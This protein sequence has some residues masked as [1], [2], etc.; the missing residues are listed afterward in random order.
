MTTY[1]IKD[2][3]QVFNLIKN[4]AIFYIFEIDIKYK[5]EK[6]I[7]I[8]R[9]K[10][11]NIGELIKFNDFINKDIN[12]IKFKIYNLNNPLNI[13]I[14]KKTFDNNENLILLNKQ[15]I[16]IQINLLNEYL[17]CKYKLL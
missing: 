11:T 9:I 2:N 8:K 14:I 12:R 7:K 10:N 15:N 5:D 13:L 4:D 17:E 3:R 6:N 1:S 16:L